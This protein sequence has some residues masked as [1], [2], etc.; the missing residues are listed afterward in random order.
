MS[1]QRVEI[2]QTEPHVGLFW[3]QL[4]IVLFFVDC[5]LC[6]CFVNV[7]VCVLQV[8]LCVCVCVYMILF[9]FTTVGLRMIRCRTIWLR[10]AIGNS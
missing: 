7:C 10:D 3:W 6:M 1:S 5:A 4:L 8:C 2:C 9:C